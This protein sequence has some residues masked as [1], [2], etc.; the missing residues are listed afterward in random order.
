MKIALI[1]IVGLAGFSLVLRGFIRNILEI[2]QKSKGNHTYTDR[3]FNYPL[4]VLWYSYLLVFFIGLIV[5]NLIV[6]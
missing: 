1:I 2:R 3:F 6:K 4:M 5:N